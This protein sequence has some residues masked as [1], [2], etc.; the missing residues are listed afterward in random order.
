MINPS[1]KKILIL[2]TVVVLALII[3]TGGLDYNDKQRGY[4]N[5][6]LELPTQLD[7]FGVSL[8]INGKSYY[9]T[10]IQDSYTL[11]DG[12][13]TLDIKKAGYN[14]FTTTIDIKTGS[15][16]LINV[17]F[18]LS[19]TPPK[20]SAPTLSSLGV[21]QAGVQI[22]GI[23]YFNNS[24][25]AVLNLSLDGS[26]GAVLVAQYDAA[27]ES[28]ISALGPGTSFLPSA[29]QVLPSSVQ[30]YLQNNNYVSEAS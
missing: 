17:P 26:D 1:A 14:E 20:I 13:Y 8:T 28:W 7:V 3:V 18:Q 30:Q 10:G 15:N 5:L 29:V 4:V 16:F 19:S 27:T 9:V 2:V 11:H 12:S 24:S 6:N 22:T 23:N 25:W 21:K